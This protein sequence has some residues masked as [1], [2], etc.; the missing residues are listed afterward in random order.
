MYV[1]RQSKTQRAAVINRLMRQER[2][3]TQPDTPSNALIVVPQ[4]TIPIDEQVERKLPI[5]KEK[6][7]K[8][9][10]LRTN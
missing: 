2:P 3:A 5:S 8:A 9:L 4:I 6:G 1:D 7:H 10:K